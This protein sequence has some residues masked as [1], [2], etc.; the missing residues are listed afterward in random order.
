MS[1]NDEMKKVQDA[2]F[3]LKQSPLYEYRISNNY[4]PVIGEGSLDTHIVFIGEAPGKNEA[5]TGKP[6]CGA[7]GKTLD[8]LLLHVGIDRAQV[9]VTN[10][11]KDRPQDNR[12]P[13]AEEIELYAP[14]LIRQFEIIQ[15]KIIATLG[16]FSMDFVMKQFGLEENIQSISNIHGKSFKVKASWGEVIIVPLYHPAVAVYNRSKLDEL[17]KDFEVLKACSC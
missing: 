14:F 4:L 5:L 13:K 10:I 1:K 3:D 17:K 2:I 7:S 16:R 6:F 11:V 12:D 15:P 8:Q 9:Y